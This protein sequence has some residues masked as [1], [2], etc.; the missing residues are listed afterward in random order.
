MQFIKRFVVVLTCIVV[1]LSSFINPAAAFYDPF[2]GE[3]MLFDAENGIYYSPYKPLDYEPFQPFLLTSPSYPDVDPINLP[4]MEMPDFVQDILY[5]EPQGSVT[6]ASYSGVY[7]VPFLFIIVSPDV[8][9][10]YAG[11]NISISA[12]YRSSQEVIDNTPN[13]IYITGIKAIGQVWD[14]AVCYHA[15]YDHRYKLLTNWASVDPVSVGDNDKI[16]RYGYLVLAPEDP[17]DYYV[18]GY[19]GIGPGRTLTSIQ[20][21]EDS[22][23]YTRIRAVGDPVAGFANGKYLD[24]QVNFNSYI[25]YITPPTPDEI[26]ASTSKG[27]WETLKEVPGDIISGITSALTT[28]LNM[29]LYFQKDK[30][31]HENPFEN[32]LGGIQSFFDEQMNDVTDFKNSLNSTLENVVTYIESGSGVINTFL[33]AVPLLSAFVTFF[34]VFCIVRKVIGR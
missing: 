13:S 14:N 11:W 33:T 28:M 15:Y 4:W 34:V 5:G 7:K 24:M 21:Y 6:N 22:S 17:R 20:V 3:E 1:L 16:V 30:P 2:T 8:I 18:Y 25:G 31:V 12:L 32:I 27:I 10:V 23:V 9:H 19:N 29:I 26:S